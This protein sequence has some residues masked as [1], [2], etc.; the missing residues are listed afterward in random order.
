MRLCAWCVK[1]IV[2]ASQE[3]SDDRSPPS[4]YH[5]DCL[6]YGERL[7]PETLGWKKPTEPNLLTGQRY[8][9]KDHEAGI[10]RAEALFQKLKPDKFDQGPTLKTLD[11]HSAM[12]KKRN[13]SDD[14]DAVDHLVDKCMNSLT[15][16]E[17]DF[18][19][20]V[21]GVLTGGRGLTDGQGGKLDEIWE[22]VVVRRTR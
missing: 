11:Y 3:K 19:D 21:H 15:A 2:H 16:W 18:L 9:S 17:C 6:R 20:D 14:L 1:P 13:H 4:I 8:G 12:G 7:D 22:A 10:E 5:E